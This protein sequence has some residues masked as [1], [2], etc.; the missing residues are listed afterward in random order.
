MAKR[1]KQYKVI[2]LEK[3]VKKYAKHRAELALDLL[4]SVSELPKNEKGLNQLIANN[5]QRI[6]LGCKSFGRVSELAEFIGEKN[7][8][9]IAE[10][11]LKRIGW[12]ET[13]KDAIEGTLGI[14]SLKGVP[15]S[16]NYILHNCPY[17]G[18]VRLI[19]ITAHTRFIGHSEEFCK[20]HKV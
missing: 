6:R 13:M 14:T 5:K 2:D 16:E 12:G 3:E 4:V 19:E 20:S 18:C 9:S 15:G 1:I 11:I 8:V 7:W 10:S 17:C